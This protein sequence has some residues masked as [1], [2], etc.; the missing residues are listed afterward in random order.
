MYVRGL[1]HF[2]KMNRPELLMEKQRLWELMP[3]AVTAKERVAILECLASIYR[4]LENYE[5]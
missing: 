3:I 4:A 1:S 2:L 5:K